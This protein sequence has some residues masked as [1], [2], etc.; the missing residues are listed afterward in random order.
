MKLIITILLIVIISFFIYAIIK[1]DWL[2]SF[3]SAIMLFV[4]IVPTIFRVTLKINLPFLFDVFIC[5][6]LIFHMGNGLLDISSVYP[7]YNKFTH[8]FSASVVAFIFLILIFV[9]NEYYRGIAVNTF[10]I[11][12]DVVV[13]TMAFGVVWEFMEWATDYFFDLNTQPSLNDT[14]GDLFADTLGGLLIAYFGYFLIKR[15]ILRSFSKDFKKHF[16][17][18]IDN[19]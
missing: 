9:F 10:K 4:A 3:F 17:D 7:I 13:I 16:K 15:G 1:N 14:M 5:L 18:I 2:W 19:D 6:A 12:F 11:M 8:F